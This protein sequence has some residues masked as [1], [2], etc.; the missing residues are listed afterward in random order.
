VQDPIYAADPADVPVEDIVAPPTFAA[1]FCVG[2]TA[3]LFA[4]PELGAHWNLVHG[5]QEF[6]YHRP[7]RG[8]DVLD[9]TP[10]I[11]DIA[12]RRRMELLTYEIDC[13]AW[14]TQEPV[15]TARSVLVL[16]KQEAD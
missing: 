3:A 14:Q 8:G 10:K 12:D 7:I 5:T 16:F 15:V 4:D 13:A 2:R 1:C 9:C 6:T 11:V